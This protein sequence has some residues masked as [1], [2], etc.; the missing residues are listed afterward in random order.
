[1][2]SSGLGRHTQAYTVISTFLNES[3]FKS[4][5]KKFDFESIFSFSEKISF[6]LLAYFVKWDLLGFS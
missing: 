6:Y 5:N 1:M 2:P 3:Y 4:S